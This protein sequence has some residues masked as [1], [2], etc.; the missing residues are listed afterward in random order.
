MAYLD[1]DPSDSTI[2]KAVR[3]PTAPSTG[4]SYNLVASAGDFDRRTYALTGI[5]SV[6]AV[7][8]AE[9]NVYMRVNS[10]AAGEAAYYGLAITVGGIEYDVPSGIVGSTGG[11]SWRTVSI[12][13]ADVTSA[14]GSTP[15]ASDWLTLKVYINA[16]AESAGF[17][18]TDIDVAAAYVGFTYTAAGGGMYPV[19]RF[20]GSKSTA[21]RASR[22]PQESSMLVKQSSSSYALTFLMV[23][24]SDHLTAKTGLSPTVTLSKAGGSFSACSGS[25]SEIGNGWYKV[26][27]NSTD[28]ATLG[29]LALHATATGAD[30]VDARYEVVA[31]DPQSATS[32]G[33]SNLDA[34]ISSRLAPTS[35][36]RTLDVSAGGEAG[37]DWANI[38]SPTTTVD[39]SGSTIAAV[40][41]AVGSVTGA[42]GSVTGAVGSVTGLTAS[43]VGA[44]KTKTDSLTF[45]VSGKVDANMLYVGGQT[46]TAAAGV[47][48]PSS[49]GTSTLTQ[50]Q[51]TGGAYPIATN[52]SGQPTIGGVAA[53]AL[54]HF[55]TLD[56]TKVY[57]DAVSGS[58]VKEL[59][60]NAGGGSPPSAA[61][62]ADAV[63]DE[64][65][66]G[67]TTSGTAGA[68]LTA[69][70]SAGDP[71]ATSLPGSYGSGTAGNIV[72]NRI[73]AAVTSRLAPTTNGRTLDV[74]STGGAGI[75]WSNVE[76]PT[77]TLNLSNTTVGTAN[78]IGTTG[79]AA[80]WDRLTSAITTSGSIGKFILD[81]LGLITST[82]AIQTNGLVSTGSII[83]VY[84]GETVNLASG[85]RIQLNVDHAALDLTSFTPKLALTKVTSNSGTSTLS[86]T[87]SVINAGAAGQAIVFTLS[88]AQTAALAL[89]TGG[90]LA[91]GMY[92]NPALIY[93][94]RWE[95]SATDGSSNC[96]TLGSGFVDV[97][98]RATSC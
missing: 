43:D 61:T 96:P 46:A 84:Q 12:P 1:L 11:Y 65:L 4:T 23:D 54:A 70:G 64:V 71:W 29:P 94:Y 47:T 44:I 92:A 32:L 62:I 50:S 48:F 25:V 33:L 88:S 63:W 49:I 83:T 55:F 38:G 34:A 35:A 57:A 97:K 26:A 78:T 14:V 51:V 40:S 24:S 60:S 37:I 95:M 76:A 82:T 53:S 8:S 73:D 93:A 75:D 79:L 66:S 27:G 17:G 9:V 86:I 6:S 18:T 21:T 52:G 74:S 10:L 7:T 90:V 67:H 16:N 59:A 5:P 69:A 39:F 36:G 87:G 20:H 3:T 68:S 22:A 15:S 72:G 41:G 2:G 58:V 81:K 28:S 56:S 19:Y 77:T 45:T 42:V 91:G 13:V 30:P 98:P 85:N 80:I 31:F 89:S